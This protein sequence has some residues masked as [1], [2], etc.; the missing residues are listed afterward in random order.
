MEGCNAVWTSRRAATRGIRPGTEDDHVDR[1]LAQRASVRPDLDTTPLALVA[2]LGR[3]AAFVDAGV[4]ATLA[5]FGLTRK[6]WDV[7]ASL[8]RAGPPFRLSPTDL[9]V[10]LIRSSG[11]MTHRLAQLEGAGL[12]RRVADPDDRRGLLVELTRR[13]L[14]LVGRWGPS[15]W[16]TSAASSLP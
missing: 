2:R 3:A 1:V 13:G 4:T 16:T 11:A 7:L 15:T 10:E 8:R 12:V 14:A 9:Y 6:A 5:E